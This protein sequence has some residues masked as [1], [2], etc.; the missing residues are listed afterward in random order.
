[1]GRTT[2]AGLGIAAALLAAAPA[3]A[4]TLVDVTGALATDAAASGS[5]GMGGASA[6]RTVKGSL[7]R[8]LPSFTPPKIDMPE[9]AAARAGTSRAPATRSSGASGASKWK[10]GGE[11]H[12]GSAPARSSW[13]TSAK[14]GTSG[15]GAGQC[16]AKAS[17][18]SRGASAGNA[19]KAGGTAGTH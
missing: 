9:G 17:T 3:W 1:M 8:S 2:F 10:V 13:A 7:Q 14:S 16:W 19:W 15:S 11:S 5:A 4:S 12:G 6:L 18:A